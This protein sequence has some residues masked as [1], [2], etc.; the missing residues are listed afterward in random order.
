MADEILPN[1][2]TELPDV[3]ADDDTW[4]GILN[5]NFRILDNA[6]TLGQLNKTLSNMDVTLT[7][8]EA[9]KGVINLTGTLTAN[10]NVIIPATPVRLYLVRNGTT[11]AFSVTVK[12]PLGT[13]ITVAQGFN[14]LLYSDATNVVQGATSVGGTFSAANVTLSGNLTV[15]GTTALQTASATNFSYTGTLT[16]GTGVINIGSGQIYKDAAGNVGIGVTPKAWASGFRAI[17]LPA[18]GSFGTAGDFNQVITN[19]YFNGTNYIYSSTG[20]ASRFVQQNG[21]HQWYTAP[22]GTAG[23]AITF[24]QAMTLTQGGN[25]LVGTT[26]DSGR[27]TVGV[28]AGDTSQFITL[29]HESNVRQI[30]AHET[31]GNARPLEI[32][33]QQLVFRDD[34][35]ERARI[36]SGGYFKA[37]NTGTYPIA[38]VS[39]D[40]SAGAQHQLNSNQNASTLILSNS[41]TGLAAINADSYLPSGAAGVHFRGVL[42][43]SQVFLVQ[44]NGNVQNTNNSYGAISDRKVKFDIVDAPSYLERFMRIRFR[45][46]KFI[47]TD[48]DQFGVVAQELQ[49][50]FPGLVDETPDTVEVKKTR[51]VEVPAVLDEEG[52]ETS[53]ATTREEEYIE[54]EPN[55]EVTLSVKYSVLAQMQGKVIQELNAKVESQASIIDTLIARIEALESK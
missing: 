44:A 12:T 45:K 43:A 52:N 21:Q 31:A 50:V 33:S 13:G 30:W 47:G 41:N 36:T 17:E 16:G 14:T 37:S 2:S 9:A 49:E 5:N 22:S 8:A 24:T 42:N 20:F 6:V 23:N 7:D 4:G 51:T 48:Y 19:G 26:V 53:P 3:G 38:G 35:A 32:K 39:G 55:G 27:L 1:L 18:V 46:F 28:N 11:G 10:V 25:L 34:T 54:R 29:R 15:A 40:N